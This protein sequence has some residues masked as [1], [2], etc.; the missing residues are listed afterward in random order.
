MI[1]KL[2]VEKPTL[3]CDYDGIWELAFKLNPESIFSAKNTVIGLK[4]NNKPLQ[5]ELGFVTKKRT[6]DQNALL[7]A[8]LTEFALGRNGG[9]KG[10]ITTENI[11]YEMLTKHG[12][13]MFVLAKE[14]AEKELL[15]S[16][17][18]VFIIDK[19]KIGKETWSKCR[20]VLGSS[21]YT[22]QEFS[23]L[24]EGILDDMAEEGIE[25]EETRYLESQWREYERKI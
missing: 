17:R 5:I 1:A 4:N 23:D 16:Y 9:R 8:L 6:L 24:I 7:W 25:T 3:K 10:S 18:K 15:R 13:D 19:T 12:K 14:G 2:K 20:C 21:E 11:Y 22:T